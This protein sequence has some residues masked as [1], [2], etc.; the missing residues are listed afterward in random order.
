MMSQQ[1]HKKISKEQTARK[2]K[3]HYSAGQGGTVYDSDSAKDICRSCA[4]NNAAE[5][6]GQSSSSKTFYVVVCTDSVL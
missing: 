4:T 3:G 1:I 6:K 5:R 2:R